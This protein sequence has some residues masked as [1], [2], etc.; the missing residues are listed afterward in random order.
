[1]AFNFTISSKMDVLY[2]L[3]YIISSSFGIDDIDTVV[4]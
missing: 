1:M 4:L 3:N 2:A